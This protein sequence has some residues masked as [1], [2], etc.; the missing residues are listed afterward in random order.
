MAIETLSVLT[1]GTAP[2]RHHHHANAPES[3]GPGNMGALETALLRRSLAGLA[4]QIARCGRCHRTMLL[5]ER[6]YEYAT[7]A[8]RCELCRDRERQQPEDSHLVHSPE[9]GHSIRV[10]DRR[11]RR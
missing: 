10:V 3:G 2:S 9:M 5:G 11:A 7:G 8:V 4:D 6:V 1:S